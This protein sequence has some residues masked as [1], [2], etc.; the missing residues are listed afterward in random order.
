MKKKKWGQWYSRR[1][2]N[3]KKSERWLGIFERTTNRKN[4]MTMKVQSKKSRTQN[5]GICKMQMRGRKML[6]GAG[7]S[8]WNAVRCFLF[9]K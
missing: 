4:A 6:Q 9:Q 1:P 7:A 8:M 3:E 5:S 2:T